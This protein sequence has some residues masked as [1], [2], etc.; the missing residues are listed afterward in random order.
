MSIISS[1]LIQ[2]DFKKKGNMSS[3]ELS[4]MPGTYLYRGIPMGTRSPKHLLDEVELL[5][6]DK[7][8]VFVVAWQKCGK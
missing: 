4:M 2:G 5:K 7:S 8:D 3:K 6:V 1:T